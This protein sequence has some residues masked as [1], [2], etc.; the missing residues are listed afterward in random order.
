MLGAREID[1]VAR[2]LPLVGEYIRQSS[3]TSVD[4]PRRSPRRS[5]HRTGGA[6]RSTSTSTS[7]RAGI[8]ERDVLESDAPP[9]QPLGNRLVRVLVV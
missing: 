1:V 7:R 9:L 2:I 4:F 6:S 8:P 3:F 5:R